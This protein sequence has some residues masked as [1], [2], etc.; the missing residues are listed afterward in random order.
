MEVSCET[1]DI[2]THMGESWSRRGSSFTAHAG[3]DE[4]GCR[5]DGPP[6]NISRKNEVLLINPTAGKKF[7]L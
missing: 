5:V 3:A 7:F 6:S 2:Y 4:G 1:S